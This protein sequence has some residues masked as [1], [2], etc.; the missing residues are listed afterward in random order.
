M[1][2]YNSGKNIWKPENHRIMIYHNQYLFKWHVS[3][4]VLRNENLTDEDKKPVGYFTIYK[5]KWVLVN[6]SLRKMKDLTL[7][8][9]IPINSMVELTNEK[10]IMLSDEEGCRLLYITLLN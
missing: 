4:K 2:Y 8:K 9:D 10:K 1:G 5:D 3:R 6:Q 7:N